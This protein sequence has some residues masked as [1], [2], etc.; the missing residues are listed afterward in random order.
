MDILSEKIILKFES[1]IITIFLV[2]SVLMFSSISPLSKLILSFLLVIIFITRIYLSKSFFL[3]L[4]VKKHLLIIFITILLF[5]FFLFFNTYFVSRIYFE[6]KT[7]LLNFCFYI[8]TFFVFYLILIQKNILRELVI[9]FLFVETFI[10]LAYI[11]GG[12]KL[13]NFFVYNQNIFAGYCLILW[14]F[15]FFY[16]SEKK[17]EYKFFVSIVFIL[18]SIFLILLKSFSAI[19][20]SVAT[21]VFF[22]LKNKFIKSLI[23]VCLL[24]IFIVLN[25]NSFVDRTIWV[26][27]GTKVWLQHFFFGVGLG[28]FKFYYPQFLTNI[29]IEPSISTIFVHNYFIH[30]GSEIGVIGIFIF[31]FFVFYILKNS[32]NKIFVYPIYGII[33]QNFIDYILYIPQNSILFFVFIASLTAEIKNTYSIKQRNK[34]GLLFIFCTVF[35]LSYCI[36]SF[37]K[38]EKIMLLTNS[39]QK[40]S[41]YKSVSLDKTYWFGWKQIALSLVKEG[42]IEQAKEAFENVVKTNPLDAESYFYLAMINFKLG[43]KTDGYKFLKQ[44]LIINPKMGNK[45]IKIL[46]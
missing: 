8:T 36:I 13:I 26:V 31:L 2:L 40:N 18:S 3:N 46:R 10:F 6:S 44:M 39:D 9:S 28:N 43:N 16:L 5:L 22:F 11:Y 4:Q 7:E 24:L 20:I 14:L 12:E 38:M 35:L 17:Q 34:N 23:V 33:V 1:V 21:L 45:Y 29:L 32:K 30:L 37:I 42:K 25:F 15:S 27:I 41:F 19:F